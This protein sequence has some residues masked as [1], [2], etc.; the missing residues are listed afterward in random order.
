MDERGCVVGPSQ[1]ALPP[2]CAHLCSQH[3]QDV[4]FQLRK[5]ID[6]AHVFEILEQQARREMAEKRLDPREVHSL[7]SRKRLFIILGP[8]RYSVKRA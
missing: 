5:G 6:C 4:G 2:A 8:S 1:L 7:A 3:L